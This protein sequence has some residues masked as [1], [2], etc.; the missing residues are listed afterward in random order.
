MESNRGQHLSHGARGKLQRDSPPIHIS[1]GPDVTGSIRH[2]LENPSMRTS[3]CCNALTSLLLRLAV[4]PWQAQHAAPLR[5][6]ALVADIIA[7]PA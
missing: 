5:S 7:V 3:A 6:H 4:P 1:G 2:P